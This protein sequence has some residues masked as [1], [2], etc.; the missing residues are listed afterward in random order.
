MSLIIEKVAFGG[1]S[2]CYRLSDGTV[3]IIVTGDV[4]PRIIRCGFV[5]GKNL[6]LEF[7]GDLGKTGTDKWEFYG[8]H[9]LWH[10]PESL[11][12]CYHP[13]NDPVE[14]KMLSNGL[15]IIQDIEPNTLIKKEM[16][17]T[18]NPETHKFTV[19]HQM[20]NTGNWPIEFALWAL[21]M[22]N[23]SGVAIIPQYREADPE[24]LLP[25]RYISLWPYT[26]PAD[27]R[28]TWGSRYVLLRQDVQK[29]P[30]FKYGISVPE[31]WGAYAVAGDLFLKKFAYDPEATYPDNNVNVELYTNHQILELETLSPLYKVAPGKTVTHTEEWSLFRG[32]PEINNEADVNTHVLPL[33]K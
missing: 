26:D 8:G 27:S 20:T 14:I 9:R 1:W 19:L 13:D 30:A 16:I 15:H 29:E 10:S 28:V 33:I 4:G 2:N 32:L 24:G 6:F 5:G 22:M 17:I 3:E 18:L 7:P 12:R 21:S 11:K 25:N 23:T 31:G